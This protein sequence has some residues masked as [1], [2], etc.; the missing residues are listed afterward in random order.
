M[1]RLSKKKTLAV[2]ICGTLLGIALYASAN[3]WVHT[4]CG[5]ITMTVSL[6]DAEETMSKEEYQEYLRDINETLCGTREDPSVSHV[7]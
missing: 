2:A 4:S 5:R 7:Q 3:C 1:K 6:S